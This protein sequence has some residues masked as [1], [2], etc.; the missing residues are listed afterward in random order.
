MNYLLPTKHSHPDKTIIA[1]AFFLLK[2]L[3]KFRIENYDVLF[4][5]L[6]KN[7]NEGD[8]LFM[9]AVNFLFILGLLS[10]HSKSDSFEYTG[11]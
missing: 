9:P 7:N 11:K 4:D 5:Y 2:Y 6:K 3:K 1:A 10:Y 8:L